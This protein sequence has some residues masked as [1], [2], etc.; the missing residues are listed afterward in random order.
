MGGEGDV[1]TRVFLRD[2][3]YDPGGDRDLYRG[4]D[5]AAEG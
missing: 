3:V 4:G 1:H 2:P 5:P